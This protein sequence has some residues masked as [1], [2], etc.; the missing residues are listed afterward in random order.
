L[1]WRWCFYINLPIGAAVVIALVL[2]L[3]IDDKPWETLPLLEQLKRLDPLGLLFFVPSMVCLILA[4]QW[5]GTTYS[6]STPKMIGL[7]VTFAVTLVI[8]IFIQ[9]FMP[10]TAIFPMRIVLDRSIAGAMLFTFLSAGGMMIGAYYLVIWF[11]AA[12]SQ[13]ALDS[14]IRL[15]PMVLSLVLFGFLAAAVTQK[16]GY[17]VPAML[18]SPIFAAVGMGMLS[19]LSRSSGASVW[20]GYQIIY[21][22]GLGIGSQSANLVSQATLPRADIPIGMAM[23]FFMQQIGGAVFLS[24]AQ[25]LFSSSLVT[26]LSGVAGLDARVIINTGATDLRTT[27]PKNQIDMVI[28]AYSHSITQ[29]FLVGAGLSACMMIG[30][31]SVK[32]RN[33][34]GK[35]DAEDEDKKGQRESSENV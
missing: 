4:L 17:Y 27:V 29:T 3:H 30:A 35:R 13:S 19:T 2:F 18:L 20:I 8:F 24:V 23:Q 12:Q 5:G 11:Q 33:I 9:V 32:W 22:I 21:G 6:W 31:L 25:N 15:L 1:T 16:I 10:K 7:L 14:G 28:D 26:T 34:K